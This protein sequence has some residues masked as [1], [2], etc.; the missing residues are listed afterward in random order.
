MNSPAHPPDAGWD[1]AT[2]TEASDTAWQRGLRWQQAWWRAERLRLPAGPFSA[3]RPDRLVGS[4]LPLDAPPDANFLSDEVASAAA[5]RLTAT[6]DG[7]LVKE[8]RLRRFLLSS[9]PMCFNL[10]GHFQHD[11]SNQALLPWVRQLSPNAQRVT[12]IEVEWAPPSEEHFRGGSAFD[13]FVEYETSDD[14]L[15]FLGI[16]CKYHEDLRRSDVPKV[17]DVYKSFTEASG[18]WRE[19]AVER[20]DRPGL[21]Q[22]WLN[23]LLVQS[24]LAKNERY[25]EATCVIMACR[26]DQSAR[27]TYESVRSELVN[28]STLAWEPWES[29]TDSIV[30][31]DDWRKRFVERYL[32]FTPIAHLLTANDARLEPPSV[33]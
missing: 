31:H 4:T 11:D 10:F 24:L 21:R 20:L 2:W 9:Q 5:R 28:P 29:I 12:R 8:D 25:S 15:G 7:G 26:A 30:E 33:T 16:E 32:D 17:R 6:G 13:A 23:T 22:F 3:D 18:L 1:D 19:G 14:R 27:T